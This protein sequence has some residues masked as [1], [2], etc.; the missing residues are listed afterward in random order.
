MARRNSYDPEDYPIIAASLRKLA[1][2]E[3]IEEVLARLKGK[4]PLTLRPLTKIEDEEGQP[5]LG[6]GLR[7]YMPDKPLSK[8]DAS[9]PVQVDYVR[10][11][12]SADAIAQRTTAEDLAKF[13][14]DFEKIADEVLGKSETPCKVL[15]QFTC[16]PS[17]HTVKVMHQPKDVDEKPLKEI[18]EPAGQDGQVARQRG[19]GRVPDPTDRHAEKT[20]CRQGK[21]TGRLRT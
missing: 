1:P 14:K 16:S 8:S 10:L 7:L 17:G 21:M 5:A 2:G 11:L 9:K 18:Y 20:G 6:S 12:T 15:V 19:D 13:E 3:K 4:G